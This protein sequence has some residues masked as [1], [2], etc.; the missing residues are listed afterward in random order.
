[1]SIASQ[2]RFACQR[3]VTQRQRAANGALIGLKKARATP[4][5]KDRA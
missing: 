3:V 5:S 2:P 1:V 4:I